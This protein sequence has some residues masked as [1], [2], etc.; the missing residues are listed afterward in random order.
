VRW[1]DLVPKAG[2]PPRPGLV[3]AAGIFLIFGGLVSIWVGIGAIGFGGR[4]QLT[5]ESNRILSAIAAALVIL[6]VLQAITGILILGQRRLGRTIGVVL[7]AVGMVS[8]ILR[9]GAA[10]TSGLVGLV[11]NGLV[12][13]AL[14]AYKE[15]FG[16]WD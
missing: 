1:T 6:G 13:Y 2:R 16:R 12:L 11:L 14:T 4:A 9:F 8:A 15:A 7:A 3:T 10:P 5:P